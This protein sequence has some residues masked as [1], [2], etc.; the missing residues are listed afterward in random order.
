MNKRYKAVQVW[1][2]VNFYSKVS[3]HI[4]H[5]G[6]IIVWV[7]DIMGINTKEDILFDVLPVTICIICISIVLLRKCC[8]YMW[9]HTKNGSII[10]WITSKKLQ[11]HETCHLWRHRKVCRATLIPVVHLFYLLKS[12]LIDFH[13]FKAFSNMIPWPYATWQAIK[14]S[15]DLEKS[16]NKSSNLWFLSKDTF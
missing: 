6:H 5:F 10:I 8:Y 12:S 11:Q 13:S 16:T 14:K 9:L 15:K 3:M 7:Y 2:T 4:R 1:V